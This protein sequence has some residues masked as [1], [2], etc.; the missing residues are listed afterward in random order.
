MTNNFSKPTLLQRI[1]GVVSAGGPG[2]HPRARSWGLT[3]M[4]RTSSRAFYW[5]TARTMVVGYFLGKL[6]EWALA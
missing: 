5:W 1:G 4:Y 6:I 2:G 3:A